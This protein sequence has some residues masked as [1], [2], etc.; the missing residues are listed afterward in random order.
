MAK[1]TSDK[2]RVKKEKERYSR[3]KPSKKGKM[4]TEK[5]Q[6]D[7]RGRPSKKKTVKGKMATEKLRGK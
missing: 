5:L 3:G 6:G 7:S 4:I 2:D 1:Y